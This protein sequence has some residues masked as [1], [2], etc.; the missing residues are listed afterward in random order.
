MV[1]INFMDVEETRKAAMK[2]KRA[3][4]K[5]CHTKVAVKKDGTFHQHKKWDGAG[6][7]PEP[8]KGSG[9]KA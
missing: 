7:K 9:K 2:L 6:S 3:E 8:C 4:C 5:H 1:T